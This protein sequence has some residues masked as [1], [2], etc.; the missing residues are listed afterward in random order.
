MVATDYPLFDLFLTMVWFFV[1]VIWVTTVIVVI[2][3]IFR[4]HDLSGW[5]KAAWFILV[6]ILPIIGVIAY[7]LARGSKMAEHRRQ[8]VEAQEKA[9]REYVRTVGG[10]SSKAA[11]LEKLADLRDRGVITDEEFARQKA[12][13][14]A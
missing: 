3:D 12:R 8:D 2:F 13:L 7:L 14:L 1:L 4:S 11:E 10:E 9:M 6:L 5:G